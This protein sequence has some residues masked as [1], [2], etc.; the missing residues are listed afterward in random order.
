MEVTAFETLKDKREVLDVNKKVYTVQTWK[1][2]TKSNF[3]YLYSGGVVLSHL[4]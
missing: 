3:I 1:L 2:L 4:F